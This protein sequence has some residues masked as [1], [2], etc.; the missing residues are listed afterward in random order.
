MCSVDAKLFPAIAMSSFA[1]SGK[2]NDHCSRSSASLDAA[3]SGIAR[4][5]FLSDTPINKMDLLG[6]WNLITEQLQQRT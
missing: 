5:M 1:L 6:K 4:R 3:E 2:K